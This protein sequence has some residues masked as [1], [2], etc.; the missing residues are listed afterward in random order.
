MVQNKLFYIFFYIVLL[1]QT[2]FCGHPKSRIF[3]STSECFIPWERFH[4]LK[5]LQA[6]FNGSNTFSLDPSTLDKPTLHKLLHDDP[7]AISRQDSDGTLLPAS[8]FLIGQ[9]LAHVAVN[10]L[11]LKLLDFLYNHGETAATAVSTSRSTTFD[12]CLG[13][14]A[15]LALCF[16]ANRADD[17]SFTDKAAFIYSYLTLIRQFAARTPEVAAHPRDDGMTPAMA[18]VARNPSFLYKAL[19][20]LS[21][22]NPNAFNGKVQ[23]GA[24]INKQNKSVEHLLIDLQATSSTLA[25]LRMILNHKK[26]NADPL[27]LQT[28]QKIS[29]HCFKYKKFEYLNVCLNIMPGK[30]CFSFCSPDHRLTAQGECLCCFAGCKCCIKE[31]PNNNHFHYPFWQNFYNKNSDHPDAHLWLQ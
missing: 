29:L 31:Q 21:S 28:I 3:P 24:G 8:Q 20:I 22:I 16:Q 23:S 9:T 27:F 5:K 25:S 17:S 26:I 30:L 13:S 7:A 14:T 11:D 18:F 12:K 6:F 10:D 15:F 1:G 19:E 2:V 4:R